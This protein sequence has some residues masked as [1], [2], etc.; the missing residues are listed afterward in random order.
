[1]SALP[2]HLFDVPLEQAI[3][4]KMIVSPDVIGYAVDVKAQAFSLEFHVIVF[5]AIKQLYDEGNPI[6]RATIYSLMAE[7]GQAH[8]A[9]LSELLELM[10]HHVGVADFEHSLKR[11]QDLL[12]LRTA[13]REMADMHEKLCR[14]GATLADVQKVEDIARNADSSRSRGARLRSVVE[15]VKEYPGGLNEFLHPNL[16]SSY[17]RF[18]WAKARRMCGGLWPGEVM[19]LGGRP[20]SG[21]SAAAVQIARYNSQFGMVPALFNLEMTDHQTIYRQIC[22]RAGVP[23]AKFRMGE[24]DDDEQSAV[25]TQLNILGIE[26]M[27]L[28]DR[29]SMTIGEI[30]HTLARYIKTHGVNLAI[31]DYLQLADAGAKTDN[32]QQEVAYISRKCKTMSLKLGIPM[33]VLAQ[34]SRKSEDENREPRM[35]DMRESGAIEQDADVI[36]FTHRKTTKVAEMDS[37]E[38]SLLFPKVRNGEVGRCNVA[39]SGRTLEFTDLRSEEYDER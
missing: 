9:T 39:W 34:L 5:I 28:C 10:N 19:V 26:K 31:I 35:S 25:F 2:V 21:K 20:G 23:M 33:V 18:P 8:E 3:L 13:I 16:G 38:Y 37:H 7:R 36:M 14:V 4:G 29:S 30:E 24:L 15:I 11:L 22:A 12:A 6:S 17:L 27:L 32:R 1:M